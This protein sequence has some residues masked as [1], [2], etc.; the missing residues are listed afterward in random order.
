MPILFRLFLVASLSFVLNL[1][2]GMWRTKTKKFSVLWFVSIHLAVPLIYFLRVRSELPLWSIPILVLVSVLG[3]LA[4]GIFM[5]NIAK[6]K[7][8]CTRC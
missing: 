8:L 7:L 1:P 5:K 2:L 3:Q 4:G 6:A